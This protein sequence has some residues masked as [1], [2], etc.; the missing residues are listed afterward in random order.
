MANY[1]LKTVES[2]IK[3]WYI[4][5]LIGLIFIITGIYAFMTPLESYI[6][7]SFLF[8]ISFLVSGISEIIF[9]IANRKEIDNW[10]WPLAFG[11]ITTLIG[12]LLVSNPGI[13]MVTLSFYIGFLVLFRSTGAVS[14]AMDL[15]RYGVSEWSN[16]MI[17]GVLG[18][19]LS[20]ILIWNP[21]FAGIA[22][23]YWTGL[24]L[25]IGGIFSVYLAFALR[26]LNKIPGK[27]SQ[28]LKDRIEALDKELQA[29]INTK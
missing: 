29:E 10:G 17:I 25:I 26:K 3:H 14:Y 19:L 6:A 11:I 23:V 8:S 16:L 28:G 13:S 1:L 21:F 15:K 4:P 24:T 27:I 7:L 20:F 9:S 5:L 18:I 12:L 22:A 2:S